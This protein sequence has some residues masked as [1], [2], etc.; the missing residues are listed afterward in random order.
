MGY[1]MKKY[2]RPRDERPWKVHPVWRGIGCFLVILMP[3]MAWVGAD[4]FLKT[5]TLIV[6]PPDLLKPVLIPMS[7]IEI[8][9]LGITVVNNF[10]LGIDLTYDKL[11]FAFAFLFLGYG[12][13]LVFYSIMY[14]IIG[15]PRYGQFDAP[16]IPSSK[17]R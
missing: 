11:L 4:L 8:L 6:L 15:P 5:N 14:R 12:A 1:S 17:R 2:A 3:I 10:L 9:D 7:K 16:P 13:L